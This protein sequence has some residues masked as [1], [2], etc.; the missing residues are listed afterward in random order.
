MEPLL[1]IA[2]IGELVGGLPAAWIAGERGR[3]SVSGFL[4]GGLFG[5]IAVVAIGLAPAGTTGVFVEC[6]ECREG[7]RVEATCCPHCRA[8]IPDEIEEPERRE[9]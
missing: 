3:S 1:V 5:P 7:I 6:P 4:A 2:A 9:P 8:D